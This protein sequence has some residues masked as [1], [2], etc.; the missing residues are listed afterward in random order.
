M[1]VS[2]KPSP[3]PL[4]AQWGDDEEDE[5]LDDIC[6]VC[7]SECTCGAAL[8]VE[9]QDALRITDAQEERVKG[10]KINAVLNTDTRK[11]LQPKIITSQVVERYDPEFDM[12]PKKKVR[13]TG[14]TTK[15]RKKTGPP[16]PLPIEK[17]L[18]TKKKR[19]ISVHGSDNEDLVV[20]DT[21][22]VFKDSSLAFTCSDQEDFLL[23][24]I[25]FIAF[26]YPESRTGSYTSSAHIESGDD[27]N[28]EEE[29]ERA[30]IEEFMGYHDEP[31]SFE[32]ID[33]ISEEEEED[34]EDEE[35]EEEEYDEEEGHE[36][37]NYEEDEET[38]DSYYVGNIGR[39][40]SS[41]EEEEEEYDYN[42]TRMHSEAE[43]VDSSEGEND[44]YLQEQL[45]PFV[46]DHGNLLD[47]IAAAFMQV[48]APLT[49]LPLPAVHDASLPATSMEEGLNF[50]AFD[51]A[52]ALAATSSA[53]MSTSQDPLHGSDSHCAMDTTE[54]MSIVED[55]LSD[56][57]SMN[58][59]PIDTSC[60]LSVLAAEASLSMPLEIKDHKKDLLMGRDGE[61]ICPP[62]T[63]N[64]Y[65]DISMDPST[66]FPLSSMKL[67]DQLLELLRLTST[68]DLLSTAG[69][70]ANSLV[71]P[72]TSCSCSSS[73]SLPH[74][75]TLSTL[76]TNH[77]RQLLSKSTCQ[78]E[79]CSSLQASVNA[80]YSLGTAVSL[81]GINSALTEQPFMD[82]LHS[83]IMN[84][85]K[86]RNLAE[87]CS[88]EKKRRISETRMLGVGSNDVLSSFHE[89][90]IPLL[91]PPCSFSPPL[92][93]P[94]S[95]SSSSSSASSLSST[96]TPTPTP[97]SEPAIVSMDELVDTSQLYTR[98]SS[99]SPSPDLE[100][101]TQFSRDLS[102]WQRVPIGAFRLM[103][104]K[105]RLWLER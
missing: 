30:I 25:D 7:D 70:V 57:E 105:N 53:S 5:D 38:A 20:D 78:L 22:E 65:S 49:N 21:H 8:A 40:S 47:S 19:G 74:D 14:G 41:E 98:S 16:P 28:I 63:P 86:R 39:W 72:G 15:Q 64:I 18:N 75:K 11:D 36:H 43:M 50:S 3:P 24:P 44:E 97:K 94:S 85:V 54:P 61:I 66:L 52:S 2:I 32:A 33:E 29:E 1:T 55:P 34:E 37:Y 89:S 104:A 59:M 23:D 12:K 9:T 42:D 93:P 60:P 77:T 31:N 101:D 6:P 51:L 62:N 95:S 73:L 88:N 83:E 84:A 10:S 90:S 87:T 45:L 71:S 100:A 46:D 67:Q 80:L 56:K 13:K 76:P 91:S 68:S 81:S 35:D 103:S 82:A 96:A 26:P 27:E 48:L 92:P 102:R 69:S 99:R 58:D 17:I 4:L 79:T